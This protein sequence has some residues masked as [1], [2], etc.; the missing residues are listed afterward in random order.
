MSKLTPASHVPA[1]LWKVAVV[2]IIS[3]FGLAACQI[4]PLSFP[5]QASSTET[6]TSTATLPPDVLETTI[7]TATPQPS[8]QVFKDIPYLQ[9]A[10]VAPN[11]LSLDIYTPASYGAYP[12]IVMVHGGSWRSGDKDTSEV[13]GTKSQFF[14]N[15]GF[16]FVSINYRLSPVVIYPEQVEDVAAALA[17]VYQH[18]SG[19]GGDPGQ[20][21]VMGHSA[22]GQLAALVATDQRYLAIYDMKP[23]D[24]S[25]V[26]LLDAAGTRYTG[27]HVTIALVYVHNCLWQ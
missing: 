20:L 24:L 6:S 2:V 18:I 14:T 22:G 17:W 26:I 10:G 4:T 27:Q 15:N 13:S 1:G 8:M 12:V 9:E 11:L 25:G 16:V 23:G 3:L 5:F 21:Y 19:Y 7:N